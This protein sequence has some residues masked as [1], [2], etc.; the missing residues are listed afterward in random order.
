MKKKK[1]EI[2][3][4]VLD[5]V[6]EWSQNLGDWKRYSWMGG[7]GKGGRIV[8]V[9]CLQSWQCLRV[10]TSLNRS[11]WISTIVKEV[12]V[13]VKDERGKGGVGGVKAF[14]VRVE[15]IEK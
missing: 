5:E 7:R 3:W 12:L 9:H 13:F 1:N 11:K 4:K 14:S 8:T 15:Q 6:K 2:L 10:R